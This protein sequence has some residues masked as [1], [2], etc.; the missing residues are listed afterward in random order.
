[1]SFR[2]A[3]WDADAYH[4]ISGPQFAWGQRV[5][6]R[7]DLRGDE[8]VLD[9][10]CGTGRLTS[11]LA[12]R[13]PEGRII[14]MDRSAAMTRSAR[15]L[16]PDE[17][18]VVQADL[19]ALPFGRA[20][21]VIFSTATFHWVLEPAGLHAQLFTA[22]KGGGRLHAQCGGAGNLT[23]LH[24]RMH[25][26]MRDARYADRYTDWREPWYFAT[27]EA[28][29]ASLEAAG[30]TDIRCDLEDAPTRFADEAAYREFT[31]RVVL[32]DYFTRVSAKEREDMLDV[33]CDAAAADEAPYT[34]DYV[35]LNMSATRPA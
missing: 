30:F 25:A 8:V 23:R 18:G 13:V 5:L 3:D 22:L 11:L 6:A 2:R 4:R 26:L 19:L 29:V 31:D 21:D 10:G 9:A 32:A 12:A 28:T 1:M 27:P 7:L 24:A 15:T 20:F 16:L 35:R 33:L 17:V 34:L 14:S